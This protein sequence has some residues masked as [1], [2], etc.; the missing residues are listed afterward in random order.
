MYK[1][2]NEHASEQKRQEKESSV[3]SQAP[4]SADTTAWAREVS[5]V[6]THKKDINIKDHGKITVCHIPNLQLYTWNLT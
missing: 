3:L 5:P 4:R 2:T 1:Y 6:A